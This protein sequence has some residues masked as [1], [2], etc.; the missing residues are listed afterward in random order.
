MN[1]DNFINIFPINSEANKWRF[2]YYY[3]KKIQIQFW[4]NMG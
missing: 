2:M 4:A 1:K 3:L